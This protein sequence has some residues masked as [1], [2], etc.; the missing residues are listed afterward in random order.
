[1][2]LVKEVRDEARS[3]RIYAEKALRET[4]LLRQEFLEGSIQVGSPSQDQE[5]V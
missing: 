3:G 1:M 2:D 4:Q 5:N